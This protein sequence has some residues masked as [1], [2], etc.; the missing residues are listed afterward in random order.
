MRRHGEH[1]AKRRP[2]A[3]VMVWAS[4]Y[5]QLSWVP[6]LIVVAT[7]VG[8]PAVLA[9]A[10]SAYS[11]SNMVGNAAFGLMADRI[12]RTRVAAAG[13]LAVAA[14]TLAHLFVT[15]PSG[16]VGMRLIH[17]LAAAS[18]A[19]AAFASLA[20]GAPRGQRGEVMARAGLVIALASMMAPP[21]NGALKDALGLPATLIILAACMALIGVTGLLRR[22][23]PQQ[24]EAVESVAATVEIEDEKVT[25]VHLRLLALSCAIGFAVMFC[26]NVLF[27]AFPLKTNALGMSAGRT[28]SLLIGFA[29]GAT[30][31]FLPPLSRLSDRLGRRVPVMLGLVIASIGFAALAPVEAPTAMAGTLFIY[32]LG[33]GLVFPSISALNADAVGPARRG[34]AFGLLTA[35]FSAGSITG[36]LVTHAVSAVAS[37]F[38]TSSLVLLLALG[39]TALFLPRRH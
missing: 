21:I 3:L 14:S 16:L 19:P 23:S 4:F 31:A 10:A 39:A 17:G 26:Q 11:V 24:K 1:T 27:Y 15:S 38:T 36:P 34:M 28:G 35:A 6:L 33:F 30:I 7:A 12:N 2:L 37:P 25:F 5:E 9:F 22:P 29:L 18:I 8:D 13:F 32:G 20:D